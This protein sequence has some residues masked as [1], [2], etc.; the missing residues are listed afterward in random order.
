M[1]RVSVCAAQRTGRSGEPMAS[2]R[3]RGN[4][5]SNTAADHIPA[6]KLALAQLSEPARKRVPVRADSGGGTH[7]FLEWLTARGRRLA[8]SVGFTITE[9][10][11]HAI[12]KIPARPGT[13][14]DDAHG[15]ARD[16]PRAAHLT[17]L[18]DLTT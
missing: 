18:P 11:Q 9:E 8:H 4:A 7:E 2:V 3:R 1:Y 12:G 6:V 17:G 10:A 16:G 14:A 5:G 15:Q 13:P